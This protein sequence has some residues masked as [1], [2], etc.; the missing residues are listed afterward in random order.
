MNPLAVTAAG[1]VNFLAAL[2]LGNFLLAH[3]V[4]LL[5]A[6]PIRDGLAALV[7]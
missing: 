7:L 5:P 6:G 1:A 2:I 3:L 4:V